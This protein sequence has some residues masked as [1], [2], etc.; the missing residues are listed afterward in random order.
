MVKVLDYWEVVRN[1]IS[2]LD[3]RKREN[4]AETFSLFKIYTR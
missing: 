1:Y 2:E 4:I 3:T